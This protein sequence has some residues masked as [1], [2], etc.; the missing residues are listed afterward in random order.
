LE[1]AQT[2]LEIP[3]AELDEEQQASS[4]LEAS[5]QADSQMINEVYLERNVQST[6]SCIELG[7]S[8]V[9]LFYQL[10]IAYYNQ[11]DGHFLC[12][13]VCFHGFTSMTAIRRHLKR[14]HSLNNLKFIEVSQFFGVQM[15]GL[16][17]SRSS[18][19]PLLPIVHA[20]LCGSGHVSTGKTVNSLKTCL[21]SQCGTSFTS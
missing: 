20:R 4:E 1:I 15:S 14:M 21:H 8:H 3:L 17:P 13:L 7:F 16:L 9:S 6:K 18:S 19:Y 12:C 11:Q 10:K 2:G 5:Q